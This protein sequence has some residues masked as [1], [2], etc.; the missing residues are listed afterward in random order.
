MLGRRATDVP[1]AL[2]NRRGLLPLILPLALTVA[3]GLAAGQFAEWQNRSEV[4]SERARL[5]DALAGLLAGMGD[6]LDGVVR[7]DDASAAVAQDKGGEGSQGA[8]SEPGFDIVA[9]VGSSARPE[10][11]VQ[12]DESASLATDRVA[13]ALDRISAG[14]APP[15]VDV[16]VGPAVRSTLAQLGDGFYAVVARTPE[17]SQSDGRTVVGLR[18]LDGGLLEEL[19]RRAGTS[20]I[21]VVGDPSAAGADMSTLPVGTSGA[22]LLAWMAKRPGDALLAAGTPLLLAFVAILFGTAAW[23]T[24][25]AMRELE[26]K[27]E[28]ALRLAQVDPLC[29]IANQFAFA[30]L[31][32]SEL[33]R[34][35]R[36]GTSLGLMLV[37]I[38]RF[39]DINETFGHQAGDRLIQAVAGRIA[40]IIDQGAVLARLGGDEFAILCKGGIPARSC[41]TFARKILLS[42]Q[43]AV[44]IGPRPVKVGLSIGIALHPENGTGPDDLLQAADLALRCAKG[45]GRNRYAF[46]NARL[47]D[48]LNSRQTIEEELRFAIHHDGLK[49]KYQPVWASDGKRMVG[50]EALVRWPHGER[51]LLPPDTFIRLAEDRGLIFPLGE[52]VLRQACKDGLR[53]PNL[54]IA[55]NVS[56][57][58][59]LDKGFVSLVERVL[60]ETGFDPARLELELTEGVIIED[61]DEAEAATIELRGLGVRLALDDFGTGYASLIYLRRFA[62]D[63]IKIDKSFLESL[64]ATGESAIIVHS[65][66]H[67]GR[68]LGLTVTAEGVETPEQHRFLQAVGCH[69]LQGFLFSKPVDAEVIDAM[70]AADVGEQRAIA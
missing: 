39:K 11:L 29:G 45:E 26:G 51:G 50:V 12:R 28:S 60:F 43:D 56:P 68:A 53:W 3:L 37:N 47:G 32:A 20:P 33:A 41:E 6:R 61:A 69:E 17:T 19:S 15:P 10:I 40:Q 65:A 44:E 42:T 9:R 14:A 58:Q 22:A 31:L 38:D 34:A 59:F 67:L 23:R 7:R 48:D 49:L 13:R 54:K 36:Q 66:V 52:W 16:A 57:V 70:L 62:F 35:V 27:A 21:A 25:R 4:T 8:A 46:F 30:D 55:V 24:R 1:A 63:K 18:R 2:A 5:A 64:E